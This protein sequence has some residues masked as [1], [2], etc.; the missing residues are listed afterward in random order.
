MKNIEGRMEIIDI[1]MKISGDMITYEGDPRVTVEWVK[2]IREDGVVVSRICMGLHTGTHVD[3]PA[4]Y[5]EDGNSIEDIDLKSLIGRAHVCD[6]TAIE[7]EIIE[8]HLSNC[9]IREG[10]IILL[11]TGN[12]RLLR[13][14]NFSGEFVHLSEDAADYLVERKIKAVGID[15]LSIE[16]FNSGNSYV[17]RKL[18]SNNI[19]VIEGIDLNYVK[20]G[21]YTLFCLPLKVEGG[22]AAPARCI[23]IK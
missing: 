5:L 14:K 10:E 21:V 18:L 23:L 8:S 3:A 7:G 1:S 15:Y 6:L 2:N 20:P 22:E 11:K 16:K 9:D 19:P 13:N 17:H 4:H 12:S